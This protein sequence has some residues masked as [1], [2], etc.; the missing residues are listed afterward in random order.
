MAK[1]VNCAFCGKEITK[2]L[3]GE[4]NQLDIASLVYVDCCDECYK[5]R[6]REAKILRHRFA[7]KLENYKWENRAKPRKEQILEMYK[8]YSHECAVH[9]LE[10][11]SLAPTGVA[12]FFVYDGEGHF[13]WL[14]R[15]VGFMGAD[16]ST[17]AKIETIKNSKYDTFGFTKDDIS[18]IEFR[19]CHGEFSG[20]FHK[21]YSVEICLNHEKN[22]SFKPCYGK[23]VAIGGGFGFGYRK[24]ARKQALKQLLAFKK[25]IGSDLEIREVKKFR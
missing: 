16:I 19:L 23:S 14:E 25:L 9:I 5:E 11:S 4:N 20:L 10:K 22:L 2:G 6:K 3:F 17:E 15:R 12:E 7:L 13:G 21:G 8:S 24:R 18:C 1:T